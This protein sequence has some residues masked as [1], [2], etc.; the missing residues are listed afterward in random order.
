[1]GVHFDFI[2]W[3]QYVDWQHLDRKTLK[4]INA[5]L[6][7]IRRNGY[8]SIGKVEKL[9]G[10][11]SGLYSARIDAKNRLVFYVRGDDVV[12]ASCSGHYDD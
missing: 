2:A 1:M 9:K 7:S 3:D 12:I 10:N 8:Q 11:L 5:L 4:R 6:E